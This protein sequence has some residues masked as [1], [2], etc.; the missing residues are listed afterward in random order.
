[1]VLY[2]ENI[3]NIEN[4]EKRRD[5]CG[6]GREAQ[7]MDGCLF[8]Y[9]EYCRPAAARYSTVLAYVCTVYMPPSGIAST[10]LYRCSWSQT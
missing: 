2:I 4:I 6:E 1:M 9:V 3:E 8:V 5:D 7:Q 10:L